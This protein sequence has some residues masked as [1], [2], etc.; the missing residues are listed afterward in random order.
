MATKTAAKKTTSR[1]TP[2]RRHPEETRNRILRKAVAEFAAKG[3]SGA[4]IDAIAARAA[5]NIRM[6]YH[7]FGSKEKLYVEVFEHVLANLR[8]EELK[9]DFSEVEPLEG[10]IQM[11]DFI[12]G[13]FSSHPE[14]MNLLSSENLNR[15]KFMKN[16]ERIPVMASPVRKLISSLLRR[17]ESDGTVRAGIDPL[18]LYVAMVSLACY[19]KSNAYTLSRIF[20]Q[21]L[22]EATWQEEHKRQVHEMLIRFMGAD[23]RT[24]KERLNL[25]VAAE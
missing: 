22:L 12:D 2:A 9:L 13:H 14:L 6:I 10:L 18:H 4:R 17:G 8:K 25:Y 21:D 1:K 5:T 19:P 23:D 7:Y 16:S 3:F 15:A 24:D 20:K 11:F